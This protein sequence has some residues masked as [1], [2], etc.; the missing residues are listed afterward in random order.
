[1]KQILNKSI[2]LN[3]ANDIPD[4]NSIGKVAWNFISALY[5]LEWDSLIT[6]KDKRTF[7]QKVSSKFTLKIQ[8]IKTKTIINKQTDKPTSFVNLPLPIPAETPKEVKEISRF[9]KKSSQPTENKN[10]KKLYI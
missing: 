5:K 4:L 8:K 9:F 2:K 6:V 7:R 3:R 10:A 1:M